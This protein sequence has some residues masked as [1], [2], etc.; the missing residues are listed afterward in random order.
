MDGLRRP[1]P[2]EPMDL[3]APVA[4]ARQ[5]LA[6][7]DKPGNQADQLACTILRQLLRFHFEI[8]EQA[9]VPKVAYDRHLIATM[10]RMPQQYREDVR[11]MQAA[12]I[13]GTVGPD[14]PMNSPPLAMPPRHL[15]AD[16]GA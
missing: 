2:I 9:A 3:A 5:F 12:L 13:A 15:R 16:D 14:T 1:R 4:L 6:D 10:L 7:R 8:A 11:Y